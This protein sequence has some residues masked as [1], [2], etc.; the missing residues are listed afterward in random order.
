MRNKPN[1]ALKLGKT[2]AWLLSI[3]G[4]M[5]EKDIESIVMA[6]LMWSQQLLIWIV[7]LEMSL[8]KDINVFFIE[9]SSNSEKVVSKAT[10]SLITAFRGVVWSL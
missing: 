9:Q 3:L 10:S 5:E 7:K 1:K 8:W 2:V 4:K 6:A